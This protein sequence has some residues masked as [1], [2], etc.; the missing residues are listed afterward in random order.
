LLSLL[1]QGAE[2][3]SGGA[4]GRGKKLACAQLA[5]KIR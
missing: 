4:G 5:A 3:E 1:L 2:R